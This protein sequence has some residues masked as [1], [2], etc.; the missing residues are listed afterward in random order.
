MS[1]IIAAGIKRQNDNKHKANLSYS[2]TVSQK[3]QWLWTQLSNITHA[4]QVPRPCIKFLVPSTILK[5]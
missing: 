3:H 1:V 2:Q 4:Y 5:K